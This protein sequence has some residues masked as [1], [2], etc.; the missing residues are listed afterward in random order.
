MGE[1]NRLEQLLAFCDWE[2]K[3]RGAHDGKQHIAE[4]AYAEIV[5]LHDEL[6]R[7]RKQVEDDALAAT[8]QT[9]GQYRSALLAAMRSN[10]Q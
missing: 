7:V 6:L 2:R 9:L 8:F 4:W 1:I 10:A 5:A 3:H